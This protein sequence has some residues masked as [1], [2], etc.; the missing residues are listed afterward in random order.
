MVI[1]RTEGQAV[2]D[3]RMIDNKSITSKSPGPRAF[4]LLVLIIVLTQAGI[5]AEG[6]TGD[7]AQLYAQYCSVCHGDQGDADSHVVQGMQPPPRD[8]TSAEARRVLTRERMIAAVRDGVPGTAMAGWKTQLDGSQIAAIVDHV[9]SRFMQGGPAG[10]PDGRQ[11]YAENCSVCHGDDGQGAVWG[12]T[13]LNP[14]PVNFTDKS[15]QQRLTRERMIAS[16]THGRSGTAMAGFAT[17]L[18]GGQISAVVDFIRTAYMQAADSERRPTAA[19]TAAA[20]A[21]GN[22]PTWSA[23]AARPL[24][25]G[26]SGDPALGRA[27][28]LQNCTA[29]HGEKGDG[30]GPRAYFIFP[31]PR[32]LRHPGMRGTFDRPKLFTAIK[33]GVRGREMPAW[34]KVLDDQQ[35][36]H[37][38]EY[39]YTTFVNPAH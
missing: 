27:F 12:R 29:C 33:D 25:H 6:Q 8:F 30:A 13:S 1:V 5:P 38:T 15:V 14:P 37:I 9:R 17:Q 32:D 2:K 34:G 31:K 19:D 3:D 18:D 39:V 26:L 20:T 35:I 21:T 23:L 22:P 24:P 10:G 11:I 7:G 16:V 36:A 4:H 28:F